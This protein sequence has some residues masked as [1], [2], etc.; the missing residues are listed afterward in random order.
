MGV[1]TLGGHTFRLDPTGI[2][3]N[4]RIKT[5]M[6]LTVGGKV[7]QIF[8]TV[9][10]DMVVTG[11]FGGTREQA[12]FF[13]KAKAWAKESANTATTEPLRFTYA[14]HGW[15]FL[16]YLTRLDQEG[17]D[18]SIE[19]R[20]GIFA[21]GWRMTLF[22]VE[23]NGGL[24]P[25]KEAAQKAYIERLAAGIGWKQ[26]RFNGPLDMTQVQATMAGQS[27]T[28]FIMQGVDQGKFGG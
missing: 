15:D 19:L 24:R 12:E 27:P 17:S 23:D 14:P 1:A 2:S 25:V 22:I 5:K 26:T 3:W 13:E 9:V 18:E 21:P 7:V 16:V 28:D 20:P 10:D 4:Y 6:I 11:K 8:G